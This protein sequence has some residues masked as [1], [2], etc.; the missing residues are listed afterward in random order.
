MPRFN[1]FSGNVKTVNLKIFPDYDR[2]YRFERKF[3]KHS[4]ERKNPKEFIEIWKDISLRLIWKDKGRNRHCLFPIFW[5]LTRG[6]GYPRKRGG[7]RKSGC[8]NRGLRHLCT[9]VPRFQEN[10]MQ[11]L[12]AF[13]L[14]FFYDEKE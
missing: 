12:S 1:A 3:N 8:W 9:P 13:L 14:F 6:L 7:N 5:I 2:I 11:R 4:W 10:F